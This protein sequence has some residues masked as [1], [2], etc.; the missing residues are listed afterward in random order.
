MSASFSMSTGNFR[1]NQTWVVYAYYMGSSKL[2]IN[3]VK[4]VDWEKV[5]PPLDYNVPNW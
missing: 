4:V 5:D 1:R 3:T 2:E